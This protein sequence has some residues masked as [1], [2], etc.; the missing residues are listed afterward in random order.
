MRFLIW[1]PGIHYFSCFFFDNRKLWSFQFFPIRQ[2]SFAHR[3]G[4]LC[5]SYFLTEY[6]HFFPILP[7]IRSIE[8]IPF[9]ILKIPACRTEFLHIII[10]AGQICLKKNLTVRVTDHC[11]QKLVFGD[12]RFFIRCHHPFSAEHI[13]IQIF[14]SKKSEN[15]TFYRQ[16]FITVFYKFDGHLLPFIDIWRVFRPDNRHFLSFI[17]KYHIFHLR[18]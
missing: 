6:K 11:F 18:I 10:S 9:R 2:I 15:R 16:I 5:V 1:D 7:G 8:M 12:H 17:D 3:H 14:L 13:T 4:S